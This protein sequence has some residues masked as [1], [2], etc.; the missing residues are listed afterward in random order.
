MASSNRGTLSAQLHREPLRLY[1]LS[2]FERYRLSRPDKLAGR[3]DIEPCPRVESLSAP[4]AV[5][6]RA[7]LRGNGCPCPLHHLGDPRCHRHR[8]AST[9][10]LAAHRLT[11]LGLMYRRRALAMPSHLGGEL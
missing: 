9:A 7:R 8:T 11:V 2:M 1:F 10:P 4:Y 5:L 6:L 3:F